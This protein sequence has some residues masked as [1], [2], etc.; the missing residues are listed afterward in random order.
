MQKDTFFKYVLYLFIGCNLIFSLPF[1]DKNIMK[2][3]NFGNID[4]EYITL[5]KSSHIPEN[6]LCKNNENNLGC[7]KDEIEIIS[8]IDENLTFKYK[9]REISKNVAKNCIENSDKNATLKR[10]CFTYTTN[11]DTAIKLYNIKALSTIG[12][13]W[14]IKSRDGT[15]FEIPQEFI[16]EKVRQQESR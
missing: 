2:R 6:L 14:Y 15:K 8:Y 5:E 3:L 16:K 11:A 10:D 1:V 13:F 7:I 9:N 4:Y 12:E